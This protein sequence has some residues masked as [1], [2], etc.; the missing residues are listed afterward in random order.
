MSSQ[1]TPQQTNAVSPATA[2]RQ[3]L[4]NCSIPQLIYVAA[5]LGIADVLKDGPKR[6]DELATA[7]GADPEALYRVLRALASVDVFAEI[8]HGSF[9]L[10]P[11]A[12]LLGAD[13]PGSWR[14]TA[15]MHGEWYWRPLGA[16]LHSVQTGTPAFEHV[17]GMAFYDYLGHHADAAE[18]FNANMTAGTTQAARAV[19]AAYDF[20]GITTLVDVGGG[21]GALIAGLLQTNPQ[22]RGILFDLP[23]GLEGAR[24]LLEA[25]GVAERC[26][27]VA[28][29]F[30][31]S[32]PDGGDAY[33]LK[34]ILIDWDDEHAITILTNCHRAMQEQGKILV[35]EMLIP[36][37]N[38]PFFGKFIDIYMLMLGRGRHR[39]EAEYRTLF[40]AAGFKLTQ[41]I[42]TQSPTHFSIIEGIR[43]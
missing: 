15:L 33:L 24:S 36:P 6:C 34:Y 31:A 39:T 14:A 40:D 43:A 4:F 41:S 18:V 22:M 12:A 32:V 29:D 23:S 35:V 25:E 13:A 37:G 5:K 1:E 20:S 21:Q 26:A 2:L 10:T 30:F 3:L 17:F 16:L 11:L 9:M 38:A 19:A 28:G 7:V 42:P 8:D 27:L